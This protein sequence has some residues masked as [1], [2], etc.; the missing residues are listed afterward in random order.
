MERIF[1]YCLGY[2]SESTGVE[3]HG[4]I[5]MS[6]HYHVVVTDVEGRG[7][8]FYQKLNQNVACLLKRYLGL[9]EEVWSKAQTSVTDLSNEEHPSE[10]AVLERLVYTLGNA[11][12][13]GLV[14]R[15][16]HWEGAQSTP[17]DLGRRELRVGRPGCA[18]RRSKLPSE[19]RL[20]VT[21]PPSLSHWDR[22]ALVSELRERLRR[23]PEPAKPVGRARLRS[24]GVWERPRGV[25]KRSRGP[26]VGGSASRRRAMRGVLEAFAEAYERALSKYRAGEPAVFPRG[27]WKMVRLFHVP[28][29][30][31]ADPP[32]AAA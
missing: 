8:E 19:V 28:V 6:N 13:S 32:A 16:W 1:L 7:P 17:E 20:R 5:L 14:R 4:W 21:V 9:P 18:S 27:T 2:A 15:W 22:G 11:Q 3:V 24:Q 23:L 30:G 29:E 25:P 31:G 26:R 10:E 12:L